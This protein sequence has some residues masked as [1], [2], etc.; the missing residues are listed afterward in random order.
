VPT[1]VC[2][3][4]L[5]YTYNGLLDK[6]KPTTLPSRSLESKYVG[7]GKKGAGLANNI[8]STTAGITVEELYCGIDIRILYYSE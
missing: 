4:F 7:L 8:T 2:Q 1:T 6:T 3:Q 5:N